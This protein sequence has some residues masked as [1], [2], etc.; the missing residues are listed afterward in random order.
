MFNTRKGTYIHIDKKYLICDECVYELDKSGNHL[1]NKVTQQ[2]CVNSVYVYIS[3]GNELYKLSKFIMD[4]RITNIY[5][6]PVIF[7]VT[8]KPIELLRNIWKNPYTEYIHYMSYEIEWN[9]ATSIVRVFGLLLLKTSIQPELF[10]ILAQLL[11]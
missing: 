3:S 7:Y 4:N 2:I 6:A 5:I 8:F 1:G 10:R 9:Q 11:Y